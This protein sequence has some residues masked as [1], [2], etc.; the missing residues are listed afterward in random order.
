MHAEALLSRIS[1]RADPLILVEEISHRVVNEYSQAIAGIRLAARDVASSEAQ[2]VLA[3]AA[4]RLLSFAEAHRALQ[5]PRSGETINLA[6]YLHRLCGAMTASF[7][8]ERGVRLSLSTDAVALPGERCWRVG[9]IVSELITNCVRHGLNNGPW[10][11]SRR[12]RGRWAGRRL[13]GHRRQPRVPLS[14]TRSG[15]RRGHRPR[16]PAWRV[17]RVALHPRGHNRRTHF[18]PHH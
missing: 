1:G 18:P 10:A 15:F 3:T 2:A 8:Q 7:L 4:T 11:H 5:A 16:R 12:D 9:L 13:P 14:Q 17:R 6:D